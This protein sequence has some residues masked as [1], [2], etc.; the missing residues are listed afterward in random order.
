MYIQDMKILV[1]LLMLSYNLFSQVKTDTATTE[2]IHGTTFLAIVTKDTI[3]MAA[4]TKVN[5]TN[6]RGEITSTFNKTKIFKTDN[7][8]YAFTGVSD[9]TTTTKPS[10]ITVFIDTDNQMSRIIKREKT[11]DKIHKAIRDTFYQGLTNYVRVLPLINGIA[12]IN[13][14]LDKD[15]ILDYVITSFEDGKANYHGASFWL[16]STPQGMKVISTDLGE[17]T[18][19][20]KTSLIKSGYQS[21]IIKFLSSNPTYFKTMK[22]IVDKLICLIK[23]EI[24]VNGRDVGFPIDAAVIYKN[25]HKFLLNNKSCVNR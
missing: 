13:K 15:N 9:V 8:F 17:F 20:S 4:D 7:V 11:L 21:E 6:K 23:L 2:V 25:G 10:G 5:N 24:D 12:F 1:I 14:Y 22:N 16:K 18:D 3:W 19:K